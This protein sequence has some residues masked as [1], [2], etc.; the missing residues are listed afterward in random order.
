M[1]IEGAIAV[2]AAMDSK[3]RKVETIYIDKDKH[4]SDVA[5]IV[6]EAYKCRVNVERVPREFIE[7]NALGRTHGGIIREV[8]QRRFQSVTSLLVKEEPFLALVEGVEDSYNL[9]YILRSLYAFG[10]DGVILP[11][12]EWDFEDQTM[13]KSSAGA[14]EFI[15]IHLTEDLAVTL[16]T[17]HDN[18]F[19]II[20]AYRGN[21]PK[22]I[23]KTDMSKGPILVCIGGP[24]RGLSREV[25]DN[26]DEFVY[27]P[28]DRDFR[29]ALNAAAATVVFASEVY[30]QRH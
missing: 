30:R 4:T 8:Q 2:K 11:Y 18:K 26:T 17:L 9:G 21:E 15:P 28:Y 14:S 22:E 24:L 5:F 12:R 27:I 23:Y 7:Q 16:K 25:L 29:N 13:V 3:Y 10:C 19:R 1:I 6:H 20:S